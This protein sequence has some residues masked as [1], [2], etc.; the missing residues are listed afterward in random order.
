MLGSLQTMYES[1]TKRWSLLFFVLGISIVM[2]SGCNTSEAP[3]LLNTVYVRAKKNEGL[4]ELN[5]AQQKNLADTLNAIFGTP[6][7][8]ELPQI[9]GVDFQG[10]VDLEKLRVAAGPVGRNDSGREL[11]LY[12]KHCVHCHGITGDGAGPTASFLN[13]YPRDYRRGTFKFKST[14]GTDRPTHEDLS[15]ILLQG[16]PGTAMPSFRI[17]DEGELDSLIH[18]VR[19]LGIRGELERRLIETAADELEDEELFLDLDQHE[20]GIFQERVSLIKE[21]LAGI[22][23]SWTETQVTEV[24]SPPVDWGSDASVALGKKWFFSSTTNCSKCHGDTALGDGQTNDYDE[25]TKDWTLKVNVNPLED[26][27]KLREYKRLGALHPRNARPRNLRQGIYR[28]GRRPIDLY[29][30]IKQGI[31]GTPMPAASSQLSDDDIWHLI[32][33]VMTLPYDTLSKP[34]NVPENQ[35][36][37]R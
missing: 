34:Q 16:I 36:E 9:A 10:L 17:L 27:D 26:H 19:Y 15:R 22:V 1:K 7:K 14:K 24:P 18:Y 31:A 13:P 30:R 32:D 12:R 35:R 25:W 4:G 2:S 8:P 29:W 28:G 3:F 37:I 11:G 33:Y 20:S 23:D 6:D 21:E 5:A